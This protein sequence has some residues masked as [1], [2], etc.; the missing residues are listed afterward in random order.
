ML[1]NSLI[2]FII[3]LVVM[4]VVGFGWYKIA[5]I[6]LCKKG[7]DEAAARK[8]ASLQARKYSLIAGFLYMVAMVSVA[9]LF[10]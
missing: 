4:L 9:G 8:E 5:F 7:E 2:R 1:E 3:L 6:R 10:L